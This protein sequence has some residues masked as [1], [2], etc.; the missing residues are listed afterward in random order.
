MLQKTAGDDAIASINAATGATY[1][2]QTIASLVGKSFITIYYCFNTNL[3][4]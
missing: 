1:R 4:I 2:C 3:S